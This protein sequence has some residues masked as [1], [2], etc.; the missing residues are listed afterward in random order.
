MTIRHDV[1]PRVL[2]L[3]DEP[4]DERQVETQDWREPET[5]SLRA[6]TRPRR[7]GAASDGRRSAGVGPGRPGQDHANAWRQP[8][9]GPQLPGVVTGVTL[10]A[11]VWL[12]LAPALLGY[13]NPGG[14]FGPRWNDMLVGVLLVVVGATRL[15]R[16][17]RLAPVTVASVG[18]G[19]WLVVAPFVLAYGF[20]PH[21][22]LVTFNDLVV[23]ATVGFVAVLGHAASRMDAV[24]LRL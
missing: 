7:G 18:L 6:A 16:F 3:G 11:G 8:V 2:A 17:A 14:G 13:G 10:L 20:G 15:T 22:A 19:T 23:G 24:G 21:S 12:L 5:T 4:H 9:P 1:R